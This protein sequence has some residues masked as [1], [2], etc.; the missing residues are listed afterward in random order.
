MCQKIAKNK[1][2]LILDL[3]S[4]PVKKKKLL[5]SLRTSKQWLIKTLHKKASLIS[6][7][8]TKVFSQIKSRRGWKQTRQRSHC[9]WIHTQWSLADQYC[10]CQNW[11]HNLRLFPSPSKLSI[12]SSPVQKVASW[13]PWDLFSGEWMQPKA[14]KALL[15]LI[16]IDSNNQHQ[17]K[18]YLV[19]F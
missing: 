19:N 6:W 3:F 17:Y 13:I 1:L 9:L 2:R 11:F 18:T 14:F 7:F 15:K 4:F 5:S 12:P 8:Q 10:N 16:Y